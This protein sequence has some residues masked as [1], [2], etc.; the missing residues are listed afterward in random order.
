MK[1]AMLL[2]LF[3]SSLVSIGQVPRAIVLEH[4]TN[5]R[6][7][8]CASRNPALFSNLDNHPDVMHIAYHPSSPYSSCIFSQ[9]NASDNDLR[10]NFYGVYGG[11]P[12]I[13]INGVVTNTNFGSSTLF[14]AY[15][16][17]TSD[18]DVHMTHTLTPDSVL[19]RVVIKS[20][21]AGAGAFNLTVGVAEDTIFYNAPNGENLHRNV[22]RDF[23]VHNQSVTSAAAGDSLVF[24]Y[25]VERKSAWNPDAVFAYALLQDTDK[26]LLQAG[27]SAKAANTIGMPEMNAD[28]FRVYPI[29]ARDRVKFD[30]FVYY[31]VI[32]LSGKVVSEGFS[33]HV[34]VSDWKSG[35][36]LL[37]VNIRGEFR[38]LRL[39][40]VR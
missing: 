10:T 5:T 11:T 35:M 9:H 6:C 22:F 27:R 39:P 2:S 32:D 20:V 23:A 28:D 33:D 34:E 14:D 12:R 4:F 21:G 1:K 24:H 3:L 15:Q 37:N 18:F 31:R 38:T 7:S 16:N 26:S 19:I 13:V 40:V 8:I 25:A 17:Q 36:Y 29:P 30:K